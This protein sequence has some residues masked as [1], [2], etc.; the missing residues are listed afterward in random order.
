MRKSERLRF[1]CAVVL[2]FLGMFCLPDT[3]RLRAESI[4]ELQAKISEHNK[5]IDDLEK[6]IASYHRELESVGK[7]AKSLQGT[8]RSID[9][10][11]QTLAAQIKVTQAKIS[12][13]NLTLQEL[14]FDIGDKTQ[15]INRSTEG[16][17]E[18][19]RKITQFDD[20]SLV[21]IFLNNKSLSAFW[22]SVD[23][24]ERFEARVK[25]D[26]DETRKI[27]ID[28]QG[29][30]HLSEQKKKELVSLN[31]E[32][33][34]R[35]SIL[36]S[37]KNQ[38]SKLLHATKNKE[39]N[40]KQILEQKVTLKNAF[41]QELLQ[42]ESELRIAIDPSRLPKTGSGV[43][44]WPLDSV[45]ITQ[46]FGNTEFAKSGGYNGKGHNGI[47][48]RAPVGTPIKASLSGRV[49]GSGNTDTVC[50]G[51]SYGKWVLIEHG[52]GLSTLYAHF[53]LIKV[54]AGQNV[55]TGEIIGYSGETGYAT[56]P[57]LHFTVYATQGVRILDRKSTVCKGTY[58][59]PVADLKAYLNPLSYL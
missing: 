3:R 41:E 22:D 30:Q 23:T 15:R 1:S 45:K 51:A 46:Q 25:A 55:E 58:H 50:P 39:S 27:K 20:N 28:L 6:E 10:E 48:L 59:M 24:L 4:E 33:A 21:E 26:L 37:N 14:S 8:I 2:I 18:S 7:E 29:K 56:G 52:N 32:L 34:D 47:D 57:H 9:L 44:R 17:K 54:A 5:T 13:V 40:Y 19:M 31:A 16:L 35:R 49:S 43:L 53:S 42:F 11:Q 38:K 12:S 36:D